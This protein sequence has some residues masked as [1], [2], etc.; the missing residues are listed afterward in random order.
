MQVS[1]LGLVDLYLG[2]STIL[3]VQF[4]ANI[5]SL[6]VAGAPLTE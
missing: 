3:L 1:D 6:P 2:C 4:V 5:N